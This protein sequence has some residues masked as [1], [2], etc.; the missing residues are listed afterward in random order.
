MKNYVL[1]PSPSPRPAAG[2]FHSVPKANREE[3][4]GGKEENSVG[5]FVGICIK[6][7]LQTLFYPRP[8]KKLSTRTMLLNEC[9]DGA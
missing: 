4:D 1:F 8:E 9:L 2:F 5:G 3:P 7:T 6:K